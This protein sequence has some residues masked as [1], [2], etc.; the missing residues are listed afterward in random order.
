VK[1]GEE[2]SGRERLAKEK[3]AR[4]DT[5]DLRGGALGMEALYSVVGQREDKG[6]DRKT[7]KEKEGLERKRNTSAREND[8]VPLY[9]QKK[10]KSTGKGSRIAKKGL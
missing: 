1:L 5:R 2:L 10:K 6:N 4:G 8:L 9:H 7:V 3:E